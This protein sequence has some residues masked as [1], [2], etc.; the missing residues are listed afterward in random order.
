VASLI[1]KIRNK[2]SSKYIKYPLAAGIP[3]ILGSIAA[4]MAGAHILTRRDLKPVAALRR[5]AKDHIR[6][7]TITTED[8][9]RVSAWYIPRPGN[10]IVIILSGRGTNRNE[11]VVK[12][13]LYLKR[14]YSVVL[15]DLRGTGRSGG[16]RITFGWDEQK[17]L[18]AWY[19]FLQAKGY[20]EIGAHG[21]SLG[22][23]TI[24]YSLDE[25]PNFKFLIL[26]SCYMDLAEVMQMGLRRMYVP[27]IAS[28]LLRPM[29]EYLSAV[30][31]EE[32]QPWTH[33][34][35][36]NCP[37]M[38]MGGRKDR[39]VP[40][41]TLI[42]FFTK[43]DGPLAKLHIFERGAH[44]NFSKFFRREYSQVFNE[45]FDQIEGPYV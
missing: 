13:E 27:V 5:I 1:R 26:E 25:L 6:S 3:L 19:H 22:A 38:I 32:M 39:L 10:N 24:C 11:N 2:L 34:H 36:T 40:V 41:E 23:A 18:I 37:I 45:F 15:P 29:V 20:N 33:L 9:V 8:G 42:Q 21:F 16:E 31:H 43:I 44:E 17:D 28:V 14:G 30:T 7:I 4:L 35:Y 12:A